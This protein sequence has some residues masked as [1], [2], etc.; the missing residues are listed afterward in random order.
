MSDKLQTTGQTIIGGL[1]DAI[2]YAKG[3]KTKGRLC[4][5]RTDSFVTA[6]GKKYISRRK[7][8]WKKQ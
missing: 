6:G 8:K 5:A 4:A 1:K 3:D 2:A 7:K